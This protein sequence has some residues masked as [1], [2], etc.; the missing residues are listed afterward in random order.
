ML[1]KSSFSF[2]LILLAINICLAQVPPPTLL[3]GEYWTQ[4]FS[5]GYDYQSNG[6]VRYIVQNP[7]NPNGLCAILMAQEDSIS[8]PN[9]NRYVFFTYSTNGGKNWTKNVVDNSATYGYPYIDLKNGVPVI[10]Q[11]KSSILGTFV[12]SDASFGSSVFSLLGT[13]PT[14]PNPVIWPH[15]GVSSNGNIIVAASTSPGFA[16]HYSIFNG[17]SWSTP[18]TELTVTGGPSGQFSIES[19]LN[20]LMFIFSSDYPT[21]PGL[22]YGTRL[23]TSTNN[24]LNFI[25]QSGSNAPPFFLMSGSDTL[26]DFIDGGRQGIYVGNEI[27]LVYSVYATNSEGISPFKAWFKKAKIVHWSP[28]TGIDT[29]AGRYNMPNMTDTLLHALVTPVCQPSIGYF[30]SL[31][32]VTF[33]AFLRG[34]K[35]IVNNGDTVN[36]GEIFLTYSIDNGN[37]WTTPANI[38]NT[39]FIEEKHSSVIRRFISPPND[40]LGVYYLRDLKAG[41]W[42]NVAA[43]GK[44]PVYGIYKKLGPSVIGIKQDLEIVREYK[45]YQNYP[46]PF[47]PTTTISYYLERSGLVTLKV[48]NILGEEVTVLVNGY[49][50]KG[51]K[52]INF[53]AS[54]LPSGVYFYTLTTGD[55]KDT[56]VMVLIK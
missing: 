54:N 50:T 23:W 14:V 34:N 44:A 5:A 16:G 6:S 43:W 20:S 24:G 52:E 30:N 9:I 46:N 42:V 10:A 55:F 1:T 13:F 45:L 22:G 27:H 40:S 21:P 35:Q 7:S 29:V 18:L 17:T 11:H 56:K 39:P 12:F 31:I 33:T 26:A 19:G 47:N 2:L 53:D 49:Q 15:I 3:Q 48:F 51:A 4:L 32:Y 38:T 37:T 28:S 8:P 41:G 36:A 25:L